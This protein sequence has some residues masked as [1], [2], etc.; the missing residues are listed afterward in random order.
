MG[1]YDYYPDNKW[2]QNMYVIFGVSKGK[3]YIGKNYYR[4]YCVIIRKPEIIITNC[5]RKS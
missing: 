5:L 2:I 3:V 4:N 1:E